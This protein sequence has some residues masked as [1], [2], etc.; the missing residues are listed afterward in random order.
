MKKDLRTHIWKAIFTGGTFLAYEAWIS[1]NES[2]RT[3]SLNFEYVKSKIENLSDNQEKLLQ[4][5][6]ELRKSLEN[7]TYNQ[8]SSENR[9]EGASK[10]I[11]AVENVIK[12]NSDK[13]IDWN[14]TQLIEQYK[15]F[16]NT[17][18]MEQLCFVM[19]I[20]TSLF[21]LACIYSIVCS[22]SGNYLIDKLNLE[23]K[24]P[25]SSKLIKL[26]VKFQNYYILINLLLIT[27]SVFFII[28]INYVTLFS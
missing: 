20:T 22:Y 1:R 3:G 7:F 2:K 28:Y 4:L 17:L 5:N 21:I 19:N 25:K 24:F 18:N 13:L 12:D 8:S 9:G 16:L 23:N 26:R 10:V 15:E 14:I 27:L 11:D 6:E